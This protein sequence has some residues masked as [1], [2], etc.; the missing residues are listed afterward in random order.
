[1]GSV[2]YADEEVTEFPW[3]PDKSQYL[4]LFP[5][6]KREEEMNLSVLYLNSGQVLNM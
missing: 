6:I 1:M 4:Q 5:Q 3:T 2:Q